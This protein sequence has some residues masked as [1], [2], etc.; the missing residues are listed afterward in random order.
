MSIFLLR[1]QF[2]VLVVFMSVDII[3]LF[4]ISLWSVLTQGL[5]TALWCGYY[6]QDVYVNI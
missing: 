1:G 6:L 4:I 2:I 3:L 5:D